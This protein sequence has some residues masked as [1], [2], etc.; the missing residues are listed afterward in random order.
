MLSR[1][2]LWSLIALVATTA[3]AQFDEPEVDTDEVYRRGDSIEYI[4]DWRAG[5]SSWPGATLRSRIVRRHVD[6]EKFHVS[7]LYRK[8]EERAMAKLLADWDATPQ[9]QAFARRDDRERSWSHFHLYDLD[10]ATQRWRFEGIRVGRTPMVLLQPCLSG[11]WGDPST[12]I[13]Q[14]TYKG[15]PL[16]LAG[17][18]QYALQL[19]ADRLDKNPRPTQRRSP[20]RMTRDGGPM[21]P[22]IVGDGP[23][24]HD[25]TIKQLAPWRQPGYAPEIP[26]RRQFDDDGYVYDEDPGQCP[27]PGPCPRP[28]PQPEPDDDSPG[29]WGPNVRP[30]PQPRFPDEEIEF[31][32]RRP[33]IFPARVDWMTYVVWGLAAIGTL[34]VGAQLAKAFVSYSTAAADSRRDRD[35]LLEFARPRPAR[36]RPAPVVEEDDD[37]GDEPPS[38]TKK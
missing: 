10:D 20:W 16:E 11:A 13:L 38:T 29:P 35:A 3:F 28:R 2:I 14:R 7:I 5:A 33:K 9:L 25:G 21:K 24:V 23:L 1:S 34:F 30:R 27:G 8:S 37:D 4:G 17:D 6:T 31:P 22:A 15:D 18:L 26:P 19:Y 36:R 32:P 12:V